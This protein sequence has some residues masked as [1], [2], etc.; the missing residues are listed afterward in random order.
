VPVGKDQLPHL[1]L[2]R[3]I[4]RRFNSRYPADPPVFPEPDAL[5][6]EAPKI[7]RAR[8]RAE[9]E[10]EPEQ[11][12]RAARNRR[13]TGRVD[14]EGEDRLGRRI[15]YDPDTRPEVS[16]LL[17]IASLCTGST[18]SNR[19]SHGDGGSG[20]LKKV[21]TEVLNAELEPLR[22]RRAALEKDSWCGDRL[23]CARQPEANKVAD[24][25]LRQARAAM[26]MDYGVD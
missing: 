11:R 6:S 26:N 20:T 22:Q 7:S 14:Q 15:T 24:A 18:G 25:T 9:D 2:T 12:D 8:R 4:A 21:V 13:R 23:S 10:Q 3:K 5:L 19:R 1:E 17:Q 16:N